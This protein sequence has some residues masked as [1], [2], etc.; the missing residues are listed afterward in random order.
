MSGMPTRPRASSPPLERN[1][2]PNVDAALEDTPV[3][4]LT[5]ARQVGKSTLAGGIADERG[6]EYL[7]FDDPPRL[8]A[9]L[10]DPVGFIA[11]QEPPIVIDE[12]QRVPELMLPIKRV[13][14]QRR[15]AAGGRIG[16]LFLL[17]GSTD[18]AASMRVS[19][20]LAG[21]VER[22]TLWPLSQGELR[23][24]REN[25]VDELFAGRPPRIRASGLR[26]SRAGEL[27]AQGG[28][29]EVVA[30]P[31]RRR[32]GWFESYVDTVTEREIGDLSRIQEKREIPLLLRLLA[33]RTAGLL[34]VSGIANDLGMARK[35]VN[36]HLSLLEAV[37]LFRRVEAW[38]TN[39][40]QRLIKSPKTWLADTG[41]AAHLLGY[42]AEGV[43][44]DEGGLAGA[45]FE[46]FVGI[47]LL[48]QLSWS[49]TSARV[50]HFRTAGG[51]E[52]DI[53]LESSAGEVC[54]LEVK[55]GA[56]VGKRDFRGLEGLRDKLGARFR[57][58]AVI[59]AGEDSLPFGDRLWAL[60]AT[61][62]WARGDAA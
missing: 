57:A 50:H 52:V 30:R 37:F 40:G 51:S 28:Y 38:R 16:G 32:R 41:L 10:A 43:A 53:V 3:V 42:D 6:W 18:P 23:G 39:I 4:F 45:L 59:Y 17:T 31:A 61:A 14:D 19:E 48:K 46:N 47:E 35:T 56:T 33:T 44:T 27:I 26:R 15:A 9:A 25:F 60:P 62:L 36:R 5:G 1:L 12:V 34:N 2:K 58:G 24:V 11:E 8:D 7:T 13:V 21:R 54:G 20:S 55:L 49:D 29:P 22:L